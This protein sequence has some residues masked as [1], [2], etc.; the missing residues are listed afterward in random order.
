MLWFVLG[1][2]AVLMT[3]WLVYSQLV[4]LTRPKPSEDDGRRVPVYRRGRRVE[5]R[6]PDHKK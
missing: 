4:K 2:A 1:G 3:G 6:P 5:W